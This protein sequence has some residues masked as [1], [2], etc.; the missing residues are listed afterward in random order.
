[1]VPVQRPY[2]PLYF[3]GSSPAAHRVAA[4][5][6][7]VYLTWG[8]RPEAVA[9]KIIDVKSQAAEHGRTPRFGIRLHLIVRETEREAWEA[10]DSLIRHVD[11]RAIAGRGRPSRAWIPKVSA[12]WPRCTLAIARNW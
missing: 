10:A 6:A 4:R 2:P 7:D 12:G 3:G 1:M 11:E 8:E 5:H 9:A